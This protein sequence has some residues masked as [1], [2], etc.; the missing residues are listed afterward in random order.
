[1][2][3]NARESIREHPLEVTPDL[4]GPFTQS[5][6]SKKCPVCQITES[7]VTLPEVRDAITLHRFRILEC[8]GCGLAYTETHFGDIDRY[9]PTRYRAYGPVVTRLLGFLYDIRVSRWSRSGPS[10]GSILEIGCGTGLMLAAFRR[11]GWRVLGLERTDEVAEIG[12]R[13]H[14][15]E[16]AAVPLQRLTKSAQFDLILLFNVLEHIDDPLTLLKEC[17]N[18][19]APNG[20]LIIVVPNFSSWQARVAGPKWFHLDVPR[21]LIHFT[22]E[23][24]QATLGRAGLSITQWHF[25][26]PEHDPYGWVES[27]INVVSGRNNTLTRFLMGLDQFSLRTLLAFVLGA[28]LLPAAVILAFA[29][30]MRRRGALMEATA[31]VSSVRGSDPRTRQ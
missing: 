18:R 5:L 27:A 19:L 25:S 14:G 4:A 7:R 16:I 3:W 20:R 17:A 10:G 12:R 21:H 31:I 15:L 6:E 8:C 30:W 2:I 22:P 9:Y 29:S 23:T 11:R 26:S 13:A 24:L 1:M 28:L